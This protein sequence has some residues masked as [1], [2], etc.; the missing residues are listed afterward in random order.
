MNVTEIVDFPVK[1][2][3]KFQIL[4]GTV[5]VKFTISAVH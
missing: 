2:G 4:P 5:A 3:F 1:L